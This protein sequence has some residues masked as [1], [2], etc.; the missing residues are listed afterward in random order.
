MQIVKKDKVKVAVSKT[1]FNR[2]KFGHKSLGEVLKLRGY[3]V[4][5]GYVLIGGLEV[6]LD[7]VQL[8]VGERQV[9]RPVPK[10]ESVEETEA[11]PNESLRQPLQSV[12]LN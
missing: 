5:Q 8:T 9:M 10:K 6:S 12:A 7:K 2:V 1:N 4:S 3:S 11:S